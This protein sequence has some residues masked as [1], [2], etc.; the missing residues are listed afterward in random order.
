MLEKGT[1]L[2]GYRID[3]IVGQGGMG[4]VYEATQLSLNR[5]VALKLLAPHLSDDIAFRERFRREGQIQAGIDHPHIITVHEAG[6]TEHGLFLAMRLIRGPN[7]KDMV[8]ARE[9]DAGRSLRILTPIADALDTAHERGLTHR[10]IKPQNILVGARDHAY[11]AD[12]GLTKGPDERSLTKTGQFV[13]TLDYISPEQIQGQRATKQSDLYALAGVLYE[14]LTGIVPYPK[15]SEAAV[16]YAHMTDPPPSVS[17]QRPELPSG[18]DDVIRIAMAKD[19]DE[20]YGSADE[21]LIA[22]QRA[23]TKRTRSIMA[24]PA[25]AEVPQDTGIREAEANVPTRERPPPAAPGRTTPARRPPLPGATR[26]QEAPSE[27]AVPAP[28]RSRTRRLSSA[29]AGVGAGVLAVAAVVGFLAGRSGGENGAT[30]AGSSFASAGGL[31]LSF[32]DNWERPES[33]IK[34]K[35]LDFQAPISLAPTGAVRNQ[36]LVAGQVQASGPTLLPRKFLKLLPKPPSRSDAVR[37]GDLEAY[38]YQNLRPRGFDGRVTVYVVPNTSGVATVGCTVPSGGTD[39]S[40]GCERV[41]MTLKLTEAERFPIG[42]DPKYA[43][44]LDKTLGTLNVRR[45]DLR[46]RLSAANTSAGQ[47]QICEN[48]MRAYVAAANSLA[49]QSVSP[50][51]RNVSGAILETMRHTASGYDGMASAARNDSRRRYGAAADTVRR[52]E[53]SLRRALGRLEAFGYKLT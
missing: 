20:R 8:V 15:D 38:R 48:L 17:D 16:L 28:T 25:P 23:F 27:P 39:S 49:R 44:A 42:P 6:E 45:R 24:P 9:L 36:G 1:I 30:A 34:I 53:R 51:V 18:L 14:C 3:G 10:D 41:A 21:L 31:E 2:A 29:L 4:I 5:T 32:P 12:F 33:E 50:A 37:L 13:G 46:R 40:S 35:G 47:A 43:K 26:R 22:A 52:R 11:L 7:L 19:P